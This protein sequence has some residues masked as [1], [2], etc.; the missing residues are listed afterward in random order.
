MSF[1]CNDYFGWE[2][3]KLTGK[4]RATVTSVRTKHLL[5][6][7]VSPISFSPQGLCFHPTLLPRLE[8][9]PGGS[10]KRIAWFCPSWGR[11]E[12]TFVLSTIQPPKSASAGWAVGGGGGSLRWTGGRHWEALGGRSGGCRLGDAQDSRERRHAVISAQRIPIL[13]L[14]GV[15]VRFPLFAFTLRNDFYEA[16]P[17]GTGEGNREHGKGWGDRKQTHLPGG[18]RRERA[19]GDRFPRISSERENLKH[20]TSFQESQQSSPRAKDLIAG[21]EKGNKSSLGTVWEAVSWVSTCGLTVTQTHL[22]VVL[23][24]EIWRTGS[25][26]CWPR[27]APLADVNLERVQPPAAFQMDVMW[28]ILCKITGFELKWGTKFSEEI[29]GVFLQHMAV[30]F[31]NQTPLFGIFAELLYS[32]LHPLMVHC[33]G[34]DADGES[35]FTAGRTPR[36][37]ASLQHK[38]VSK[39]WLFGLSSEYLVLVLRLPSGAVSHTQRCLPTFPGALGV[40]IGH[41]VPCH[42]GSCWAPTQAVGWDCTAL[43]PINK[44]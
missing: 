33:C 14:S 20:P 8:L 43:K 41:L 17:Q 12:V 4:W 38:E 11:N 36:P 32:L 35:G 19:L 7:L 26:Q 31:C 18:E 15:L 29:S 23:Y 39:G 44:E 13:Q 34:S 5:C 37:L 22:P 1:F 3:Y 28:A 40:H 24:Q 10:W 16:T 2:Q 27:W 30:L 21:E 42:W 9:L 25:K 6:S